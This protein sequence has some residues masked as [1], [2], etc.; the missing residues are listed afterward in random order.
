[1]SLKNL[2]LQQFKYIYCS[3]DARQ[4]SSL[5]EM[6]QIA[7]LQYVWAEGSCSVGKSAGVIKL[8][9]IASK[10]PCAKLSQ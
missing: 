1:M 3:D 2:R 9:E 7:E 8:G 6:A 10:I 5:A 4:A